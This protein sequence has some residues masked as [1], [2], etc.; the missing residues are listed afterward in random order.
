VCACLD[1]N[2]VAQIVTTAHRDCN[3]ANTDLQINSD[4]TQKTG[5]LY[6]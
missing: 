1:V 3:L 2:Q 4:R 6:W 5:P